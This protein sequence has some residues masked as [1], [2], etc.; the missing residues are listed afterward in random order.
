MYGNIRYASKKSILLMCLPILLLLLSSCASTGTTDNAAAESPETEVISETPDI[1]P[2]Q[3]DTPAATPKTVDLSEYGEIPIPQLEP[4]TEGEEIALLHTTLGIIKLRFFPGNAPN[5]VQ[6]FKTLAKSGYYNGVIFHLV[7]ENQM[8][9]S[10]D[11]EGTGLGG[12]SMW[13]QPFSPETS[14]GMF[15]IRGAVS[16][17]RGPEPVS[18][19]SQFFIVVNKELS[20][21]VKNELGSYKDKQNEVVLELEDGTPVPMAYRYPVRIIDKY[22][23]DGGIPG[24]DLQYTVFAQVFDGFDVIDK[25]ASVETSEDE[26]TMGKPLEDIVIEK[27]TFEQYAA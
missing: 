26:E 7:L 27:I 12:N 6:N 17:L 14:L 11:P 9:Q 13:G 1:T 25:I 20:E 21:E 23:E 10:G 8:I 18:Q 22:L 4:L 16:M 3:D 15:H 24:L 19:G 2:G 5:A